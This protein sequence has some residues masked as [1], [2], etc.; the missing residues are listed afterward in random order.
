MSD[1]KA[2]YLELVKRAVLDELY[3]EHELRFEYLLEVLD[4]G[5]T[6]DLDQLRDPMRQMRVRAQQLMAERSS[7]RYGDDKR[8]APFLPLTIGRRRLDSIE[9][10]LHAI[11]DEQLEGDM[12]VAGAGRG[13][14]GVFIQAWLDVHEMTDRTLWVVDEFRPPPA[15]AADL[16]AVRDAF[17]RFDVMADNVRFVHGDAAK[18]NASDG[19]DRVALLQIGATAQPSASSLRSLYP[20]VSAGGFV[21]VDDAA[22]EVV[23]PAV[24]AVLRDAG[25]DEP[26]VERLDSSAGS[27]RKR[28]AATSERS[29]H[30]PEQESCDLSVVVVFYNMRRE[31]ARTLHSLS[32]AYQEGIDAVDYEVLVVENGSAPE[33]RLGESY[34]QGFGPEFRY[35][36]MGPDA[37]P[38]PVGALN[39]GI[40]RARGD[41][42][43]LMIDG[44]HVLTPGV[45]RFGLVGLHTYAPAIV[46]TQQWYVGPG[47]QPQT[48]VAGYDQA[49]RGRAVRGH[50]LAGKRLSTV[51]H[52]PVH[53]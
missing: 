29:I 36:D 49:A 18:L 28:S 44:A 12:V 35:L 39:A 8:L 25:E 27:W 9:H 47:Q 13:G 42:V 5:R 21:F 26:V 4:S 31:A 11:R 6:P 53:R 10:A 22:S 19:F 32:R 2:R 17:D 23:T 38:S 51:R 37:S 30:E 43:A 16:N 48:I 3:L 41:F 50:R 7:G 20:H 24:A 15:G 1:P 40:A 14:T 52:R 46:A 45:L 34:V 33:Q